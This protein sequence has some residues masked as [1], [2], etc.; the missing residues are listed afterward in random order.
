MELREIDKSKII[1]GDF[2]TAISNQQNQQTVR[3][4]VEELNIIN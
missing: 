1:A 2:K 3:K 4:D